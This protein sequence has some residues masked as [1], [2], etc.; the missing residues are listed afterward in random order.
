MLFTVS[1]KELN[2]RELKPPFTAAGY[3]KATGQKYETLDVLK[4]NIPYQQQEISRITVISSGT[5]QT[6]AMFYAPKGMPTQLMV[7]NQ[8]S[9]RDYY[10][11][12][13]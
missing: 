11:A 13:Q 4:I 5:F 3:D 10:F 1:V 9:K 12:L 8:K 6:F 2:V 7:Y